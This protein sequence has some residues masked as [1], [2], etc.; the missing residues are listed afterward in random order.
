VADVLDRPDFL[1]HG[2]AGC[3]ARWFGL[4]RAHCAACG[5]HQTFDDVELYDT[6]RAG[7]GCAPPSTLLGMV[8]NKGGIWVR[9]ADVRQ[10]S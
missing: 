3:D 2:C 1:A 5:M 6:H 8:K 4:E 10:A 7:G 9:R